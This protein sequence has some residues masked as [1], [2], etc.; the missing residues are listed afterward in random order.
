MFLIVKTEF[1]TDKTPSLTCYHSIGECRSLIH[2]ETL[3]SPDGVSSH[4][5]LEV[6]SSG[7]TYEDRK[8]SV[9]SIAIEVQHLMSECAYSYGTLIEI[10]N[11]ISRLANNYGL[12]KEFIINGILNE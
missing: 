2:D 8:E 5:I 6:A 12:T 4:Y 3:Y 7:G 1:F 10:S 11:K 9:R